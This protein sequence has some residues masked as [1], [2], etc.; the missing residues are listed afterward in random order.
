M[1]G[2]RFSPG[3]RPGHGLQAHDLAWP[4]IV[5]PVSQ[6]I[7]RLHRLL[8][9]GV[10]RHAPFMIVDLF[11]RF[12]VHAGAAMLADLL[13]RKQQLASSCQFGA[14]RGKFLSCTTGI[15]RRS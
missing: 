3:S 11:F 4:A 7:D 14:T 9:G 5:M 2:C 1:G 13:P 6:L 8:G 12:S 10:V 15:L